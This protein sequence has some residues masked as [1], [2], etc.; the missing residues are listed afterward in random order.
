[1]PFSHKVYYESADSP[2]MM[3]VITLKTYTRVSVRLQYSET[4]RSRRWKSYVQSSLIVTLISA[5]LALYAS[6]SVDEQS[7]VF[8]M[9]SCRYSH[10]APAGRGP[11]R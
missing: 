6:V 11:V 7:K 1:M 8:H 5:M 2:D 4:V 3:T 9:S 10:L